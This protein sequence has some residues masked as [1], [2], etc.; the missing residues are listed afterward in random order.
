MYE[1]PHRVRAGTQHSRIGRTMNQQNMQD[2]S[3]NISKEQSFFEKKHL[4]RMRWV[5]LA[6]HILIFVGSLV[7]IAITKNPFLVSLPGSILLSMRPINR[8][9]FSYGLHDE[10]EAVHPVDINNENN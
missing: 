2:P 1:Y 10:K 8:F 5:T 7:V 6:A 4:W 9:L 3:D